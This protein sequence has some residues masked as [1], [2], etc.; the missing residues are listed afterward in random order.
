MSTSVFRFLRVEHGFVGSNASEECDFSFRS[1]FFRL[2]DRDT[3]FKR[4]GSE[5][6][7]PRKFTIGFIRTLK[8]SAKS[9]RNQSA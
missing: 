4:D 5:Y 9:S 3:N 7:G 1:T 8:H 2:I 6:F